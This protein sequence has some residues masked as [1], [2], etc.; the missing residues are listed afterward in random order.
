MEEKRPLTHYWQFWISV[1]VS[2]LF[3]CIALRQLRLAE[4]WAALRQANYLWLAPAA[5][6]YF[7][8]FSFRTLRWKILVRHERNVAFSRLLPT[9]AIGRAANNLLPWRLGEGVRVLLLEKNN[10]IHL[11]TGTASLILERISDGLSMLIFLLVAALWWGL[12]PGLP[13][14]LF[15]LGIAFFGIIIAGIYLLIFFPAATRRLIETMVQKMAPPRFREA[16]LSF[17][18]H[19]LSGITL[20]RSPQTVTIVILIALSVWTC[21]LGVYRLTMNAFHFQVPPYQ[22]LLMSAAA[23]LGTAIPSGA[24]NLGT[25]DTPGFWVL[26]HLANVD[27]NTA[28]SYMLVLHS[29]LWATETGLGVWFMGRTGLNWRKVESQPGSLQPIAP[30]DKSPSPSERDTPLNNSSMQYR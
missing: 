12:P 13:Q 18:N 28:G 3:L 26:S 8:A 17:T 24:A 29:L 30:I 9:M 11:G 10:G 15:Y 19:L 25:F 5:L 23:N 14:R 4:V 21:E 20:I 7:G 27:A 2:L 16:L 22:L 1:A 6:M